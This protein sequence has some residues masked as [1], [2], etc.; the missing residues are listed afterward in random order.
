MPIAGETR[1]LEM[2][3]LQDE[4][5]PEL[6]FRVPA[7]HQEVT[8]LQGKYSKT[9]GLQKGMIIQLANGNQAQVM[10]VGSEVV[11][12][13]ANHAMAGQKLTFEIELASLEKSTS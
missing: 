8:R 4:W 3:S 1:R 5:K 7:D 2:Q 10:D 11:I 6:L 12:L 9:G 13:D